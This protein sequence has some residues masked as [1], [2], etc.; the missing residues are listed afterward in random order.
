[1]I[2]CYYALQCYVWSRPRP[3]VPPTPLPQP[4]KHAYTPFRTDEDPL[5]CLIPTIEL[6]TG[7]VLPGVGPTCQWRKIRALQE[8]E[9]QTIRVH[10]VRV[11]NNVIDREYLFNSALN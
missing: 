6:L 5:T 3:P 1:M 7:G 9:R 8:L 4:N 10:S 2:N 11:E